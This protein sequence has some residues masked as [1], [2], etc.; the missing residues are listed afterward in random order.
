MV[1]LCVGAGVFLGLAWL[2][3]DVQFMRALIAAVVTM[4]S[5]AVL[6]YF[7]PQKKMYQSIIAAMA[8]GTLIGIGLWWVLPYSIPWYYYSIPCAIIA[9]IEA[10]LDRWT[11]RFKKTAA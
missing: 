9:C 10:L 1:I 5:V 6:D 8:G 4:F 7:T 3:F 2:A 11:D